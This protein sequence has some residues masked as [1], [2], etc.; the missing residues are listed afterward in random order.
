[1]SDTAGIASFGLGTS[2]AG[3]AAS[4]VGSYW[5]ARSQKSRSA[6]QAQMAE[7]N[8]KLSETAA[9]TELSRGQQEIG[10]LTMRAGQ[11]K[12]SQRANLAASGVDLGV[13]SAAE[14]LATTDVM[15][16]ID[17]NTINANSVRAAWGLRMQATNYE[18]E[19]LMARAS[20][21]SIS[22]GLAAATSLLGS[23]SSVSS[24]WYRY[25]KER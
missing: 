12:S 9:Q 19:A 2:L 22:P 15:K 21:D 25:A 8:A 24:A 18:N 23:A 6:F 10:S 16:E 1:M 13:G 5:D 4:A 20:A 14:Q 11:L 7:I 17:M 3:A